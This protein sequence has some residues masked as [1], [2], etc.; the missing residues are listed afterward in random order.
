MGRRAGMAMQ[1]LPIAD[2]LHEEINSPHPS[3]ANIDESLA[4]IYAINQKLTAFEDEFS[5][6]LGEGSRWLEHVVL[7]LLLA[8]A[9]TVETTG[10]LLDL[11]SEPRHPEGPDKHHSRRQICCGWRI[12]CSRQG[13]V[14]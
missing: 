5:F 13:V 9:L 8:T 7:K 4:A 14:A 12:E 3:Q 10:L 2:R 11:V 1:L 6:T